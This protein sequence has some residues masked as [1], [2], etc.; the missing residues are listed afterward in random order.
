[1]NNIKLNLTERKNHNQNFKELL[2][3][4]L[5][6][7]KKLR[8]FFFSYDNDEQI[9]ERKLFKKILLNNYDQVSKKIYSNNQF[10]FAFE[11]YRGLKHN[12]S[13]FELKHNNQENP[14]F[15][16][17]NKSYEKSNYRDL[18]SIY[19]EFF[20]DPKKDINFDNSNIK[21]K[22]KLDT[23]TTNKKNK[24]SFLEKNLFNNNNK[25]KNRIYT[26]KNKSNKYYKLI[27]VI[28]TSREKLQSKNQISSNTSCVKSS[29]IQTNNSVNLTNTD[30]KK[31]SSIFNLKTKNNNHNSSN[32]QI[33]A[34]GLI[35]HIPNV[36]AVQKQRYMEIYN[37]FKE[38]KEK[39]NEETYKIN[40]Y[41][42][43]KIN[44][45]ILFKFNN[46]LKLKL[47]TRK[48]SSSRNKID[49]N[50]LL[51][52]S[53]VNGG[54]T[55]SERMFKSTSKKEKIK[56]K[57]KP[58]YADKIE[59]I[60]NE[61]YRIKNSSKATK[62]RYRELHLIP[63]KEIDKVVRIKEEMLLFLLKQKFFS[64]RYRKIK[65]KVKDRKKMFIQKMKEDL[66]FLDNKDIKDYLFRRF[67]NN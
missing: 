25:L 66:D 47:E 52:S 65:T 3:K 24:N 18:K 60:F 38:A 67:F 6:D 20:R 26:A 27:R 64:K 56:I 21:S 33:R 50:K 15:P 36:M 49:Y 13:S 10:K 34:S 44:T 11:K 30:I 19:K 9:L 29:F 63:Y 39:E 57:N 59:D 23:T 48:K 28:N 42:S 41:R 14:F 16:K 2:K 62:K 46:R 35:P 53:N 5:L 51:S 55:D 1:M 32:I 58:L 31:N 12:I 22:I 4:K 45:N 43:D 37:N 61:Y 8:G 17:G 54:N 7:R 40:R